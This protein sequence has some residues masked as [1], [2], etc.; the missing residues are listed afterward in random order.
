MGCDRDGVNEMSIA[1]SYDGSVDEVY[2][3]I[4]RHLR[5]KQIEYL[6]T[7]GESAEYLRNHKRSEEV[8]RNKAGTFWVQMIGYVMLGT[9]IDFCGFRK[10]GWSSIVDV[11]VT[12][13]RRD[14]ILRTLKN[15]GRI[16]LVFEKMD[17]THT[18]KKHHVMPVKFRDTHT[19]KVRHVSEEPVGIQWD[20]Y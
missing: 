5:Q 13:E 16:V 2:H 10:K 9:D 19:I 17:T 6:E 4:D 3:L 14:E 8:H 20:N 11:D 7:T 12:P 18:V 1:Y 15:S